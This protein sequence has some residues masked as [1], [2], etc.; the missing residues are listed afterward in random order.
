MTSRSRRP[1]YEVS[2]LL[3]AAVAAL[4]VAAAWAAIAAAGERPSPLIAP[5]G[6]EAA[7]ASPGPGLLV[8]AAAAVR[9]QQSAQRQRASRG[10]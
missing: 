2:R 8:P 4:A 10:S 9:P 7:V 5:A 3:V 6:G 1:G